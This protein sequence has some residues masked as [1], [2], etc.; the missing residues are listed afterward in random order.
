MA[1]P[2][3]T[4]ITAVAERWD[5]GRDVVSRYIHSGQLPA[6]KIGREWR[7]R[8]SDVERFEKE[9]FKATEA[10]LRANRVVKI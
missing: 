8:P 7:I 2:K 3:F 1:A 9:A 10:E 5:V 6:M 4:T